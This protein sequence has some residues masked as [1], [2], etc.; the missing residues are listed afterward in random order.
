MY[1]RMYPQTPYFGRSIGN[2][3]IEGED[4][5]LNDL[6]TSLVGE[7]VDI[8]LNGRESIFKDLLILSVENGTVI[9]ES[10]KEVCIIP[11]KFIATVF[12]SKELAAETF[13]I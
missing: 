6:L 3:Q 10:E 13:E 9:S 5:Y 2:R 11:I 4:T 7:K 8:L 12:L 1:T